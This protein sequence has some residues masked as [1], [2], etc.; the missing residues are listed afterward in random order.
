MIPKNSKFSTCNPWSKSFHITS[1]LNQDHEG[2]G[3]SHAKSHMPKE[4]IKLTAFWKKSVSFIN[5]FG[6]WD[7]AWFT[8]H[9]PWSWLRFDA[10]CKDLY[11]WL[12]V[13]NLLFFG[14]IDFTLVFPS[15]L[16]SREGKKVS[17]GGGQNQQQSTMTWIWKNENCEIEKCLSFPRNFENSSLPLRG[18]GVGS[19]RFGYQNLDY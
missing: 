14:T 12:H 1:N 16:A 5:T 13:L 4:S 19:R 3:M 2:C 18:E 11:R 9:P 10:M 15:F 17:I 7:F 8:P 6:M